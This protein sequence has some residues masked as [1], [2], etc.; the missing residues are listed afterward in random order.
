MTD[1]TDALVSFQQ[2]LLSGQ[3]SLEQGMLDPSVHVHHDYP[4]G[5]TR[6]TFATLSGQIVTALVVFVRTDDLDGVL[7]F[8]VGYAVP[9]AFRNQGRA[10]ALI[11]AAL[12]EM[13]SGLALKGISAFFVDAVVGT[14]NVA[15][16]RVAEQTIASTPNRITDSVS[17]LPA[18]HYMKNV[19]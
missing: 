16:R 2:A 18:L 1:P 9:D 7:C 8:N 10:K 11:L 17:G 19:T 6:L 3:I 15:S 4:N 5:M 13:K 14:D 12:D